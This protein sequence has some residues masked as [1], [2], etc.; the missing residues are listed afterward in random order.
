[1]VI[2]LA[3]KAEEPIASAAGQPTEGRATMSAQEAEP[4]TEAPAEVG[5]GSAE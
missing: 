3:G 4:Q 5:A 1:M 2:S